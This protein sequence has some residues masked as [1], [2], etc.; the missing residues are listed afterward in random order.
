MCGIRLL[1][2]AGVITCLWC[3]TE[4][5]RFLNKNSDF[6]RSKMIMM[7]YN[8]NINGIL[9]GR[10][11]VPEWY[12]KIDTIRLYI[13][14][15][16]EDQ[17]TCSQSLSISRSYICRDAVKLTI[18]QSKTLIQL[19]YCFLSKVQVVIVNYA[20][21][22]QNESRKRCYNKPRFEDKLTVIKYCKTNTYH[23]FRSYLCSCSGH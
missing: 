22:T 13:S 20:R 12:V 15:K 18:D 9:T 1:S 7:I 10:S 14:Q 6:K 21:S 5:K 4:L 17:N 8:G 2:K 16:R 23:K 3:F 11:S 19:I